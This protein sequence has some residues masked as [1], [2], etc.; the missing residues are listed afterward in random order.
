MHFFNRIGKPNPYTRDA[1]T[2]NS[3]TILRILKNQVYIGHIA[4]GK[5]R[6]KSFKMKRRDVVPEDNW[7]VVKNTHEALID[8]ITWNRVQAI[9]KQN[10][11]RIKP[12]LKKDGTVSL[13]CGKVFCADCGGKMTFQNVKDDKYPDRSRY[14][15][16]TYSNQGKTACSFHAISEDDLE[17]I[18]LNEIKKFSNI[19]IQ[20]SEEL[21]NR[22][23][24]VNGNIKSKSSSI[25]EKQLKRTEQ[26]LNGISPK[27]DVLIEQLANGNISEAMFKKLMHSYEEKQ[28]NLSEKRIAL[29]SELNEVID[30]TDHIQDVINSFKVRNYIDSLDR[31]SVVELLDHIEVFR[32]EKS[33]TGYIQRIDI[34]FN[35]IGKINFNDFDNLNSYLKEKVSRTQNQEQQ[36]G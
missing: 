31:E 1:E 9:I 28:D 20:Y 32:K 25:I 18:V 24:E 17:A 33:N 21:L 11:R 8:E 7:V 35:F 23:I 13:F 2:W 5:R 19:A 6:K 12:R 3:A 16:S 30:N 4:Q 10:K 14:R 15:C 26:E 34:Y 27:I 29:K 36:T 22:L